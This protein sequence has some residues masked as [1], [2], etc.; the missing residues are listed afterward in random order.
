MDLRSGFSACRDEPPFAPRCGF[1]LSGSSRQAAPWVKHLHTNDNVGRL[2]QGFDAE[3]DRWA[4]S[5]ADIHLPPGWGSIPY[6]DVFARLPDYRGA[7]I[8]EIKAGFADF[9]GESLQTMKALV[10]SASE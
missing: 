7:L 1:R 9:L 3:S 5:E 6:A 10:S 4:Y 8:L 2:G